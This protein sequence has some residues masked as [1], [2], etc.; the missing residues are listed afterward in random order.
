MRIGGNCGGYAQKNIKLFSKHLS[1]SGVECI[2]THRPASLLFEMTDTYSHVSLNSLS[3]GGEIG[4]RIELT[5]HQNLLKLNHAADFLSHFLKKDGT[6]PGGYVGLG[7]LVDALSKFARYT[8]DP[9]VLE[10]RREL[11]GKILGSQEADGYI[12]VFEEADRGLK[13][14]DLHEMAYM[15]V[16]LVT[17]YRLFQEEAVLEAAQG[18]M[19]YLRG[20]LEADFSEALQKQDVTFENATIGLEHACMGM[21]KVTGDREYLNLCI[22]VSGFDRWDWPILMKKEGHAYTYMARCLQQLEL[23]RDTGEPALLRQSHMVRD[24]LL[25]KD[26]MVVTGGASQLERWTD[27]QF[28]QHALAET[29][30]TAYSL[31]LLDSL[32]RLEGHSYYGDVMER[33]IYNTLFAAQSPDGRKLRYFTPFQGE[34]HYF[35]K[36][37]YCC[38]NNFRRILADLPLF[39]YYT[40]EKRMLVNLY[41]A[42]AFDG[43][44]P[45][46][47]RVRFEQQTDYPSDGRVNIRVGLEEAREFELKLRIPHWVDEAEIRINA[48][49]PLRITRGGTYYTIHRTWQDGDT[50]NLTLPMQVKAVRGRQMQ[51]RHVALV[52]GP[53]VF[54][55]NTTRQNMYIEPDLDFLRVDPGS[56]EG[57]I[58]D[59]QVRPGGVMLRGKAWSKKSAVLG[60]PDLDLE[61]SE[62]V[63]PGVRSIYYMTPDQL[64]DRIEEDALHFPGGC[65]CCSD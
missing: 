47:G 11:M 12:G 35:N 42:S 53:L 24:F 39:V 13:L 6:A 44:V 21:Y 16:G 15:V 45:G 33:I 43:E 52:R 61:F 50:V 27:N 36:D 2:P 34:R 22:R 17:D 5:V 29:C 3:M 58:S 23:F 7:K 19:G 59:D 18:L 25:C 64:D 9:A 65:P 28:G 26:G 56:I 37:T 51:A 40:A 54:G 8:E 63:D 10:L 20:C 62:F 57:P 4:R 55:L 41:N 30:V 1:G 32:L 31:W 38:P 49:A 48:E 14:W 46:V 60:G